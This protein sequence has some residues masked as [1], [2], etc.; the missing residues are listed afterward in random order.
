MVRNK[1]LLV[2]GRRTIAHLEDCLIARNLV[3]AKLM[4]NHAPCISK[5]I[6][7]WNAVS[8]QILFLFVYDCYDLLY[9]GFNSM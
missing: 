2:L 5:K 9:N 1:V 3:R 4:P 6:P 7:K 8:F